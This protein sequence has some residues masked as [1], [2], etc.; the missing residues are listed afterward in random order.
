MSRPAP[1]FGGGEMTLDLSGYTDARPR[2]PR[3]EPLTRARL[4]TGVVLAWD[5]SLAATG[6]VLLRSTPVAC[7]V[8]AAGTIK[9]G[10]EGKGHA[11]D[12]RRGVEQFTAMLAVVTTY[13]E[14]SSEGFEVVHES[15][16][17][18]GRVK[19]L[20]TASLLSALA[21]RVAC[22][23]AGVRSP[24]MLNSQAAKKAITGNGNADK[25]EVGRAIMAMT[26]VRGLEL[27]TNEAQRDA[28]ALALAHLGR[29]E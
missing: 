4:R 29:D 28:L 2:R 14:P 24:T 8:S 3:W 22:Q 27:V 23:Q 1:V 13:A 19:G 16:P 6:W 17:I 18:G 9:T 11:D 25:G 21:L 10:R 7:R 5:Q 12:L 15:P 20:G 26:W